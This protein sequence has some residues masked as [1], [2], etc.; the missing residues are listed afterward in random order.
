M[1]RNLSPALIFFV[2]CIALGLTPARAAE[3]SASTDTTGPK[4]DAPVVLSIFQVTGDRDE[5][6][7]S[8]QTISGSR[9]LENL[10]DIPNS[11]SIMNRELIEDLNATTVSE[12]SAFAVTGEVSDNTESTVANYVFRGIVSNTPLRNGIIWFSPLDTYSIERVE[13]LRGPNAFLYG[14]GTAGGSMNQLTKQ[15][16]AQNFNKANLVFGSNDLYRGELDVNRKLTDTLALRVNLA[17]QK[18]GS[19]VNHAKREFKGAYLA[20]AW[21]PTRSTNITVNL[22]AGKIHEVRPDTILT[23]VFSTTQRTGTAGTYTNTVGGVTLLSA[24]GQIINTVGT[25]RSTGTNIIVTDETVLPREYNFFGPNSFLDVD[26]TAEN[27]NIAQKFGENLTIQASLANQQIIRNSRTN[28]GSSS[29]GIYLD[30]NPTLPGGAANPNFN[31]YYTEYYVRRRWLEEPIHDARITV[32]YDLKLPFT[33]QRI[34]AAGTYHD[35]APEGY[36]SSEFV[37]AANPAFTGTVLNANTLA[38]YQAN[39]TTLSR[40]FFYRRF[41]LKDGDGSQLTSNA[42]VPGVS[43]MQ[44]DPVAEGAAGRLTHR[45]YKTPAYG[46]G[47]SGSYFKGRLRTLVGWRHDAFV[48]SPERIFYNPVTGVEYP[49]PAAKVD[50]DIGKRS[51]NLGGVVHFANFVSGYINYAQSVGLSAGI[52]GAGLIPGTVRGVAAGDGYEYGLRWSLL[53]GRLE[54]NWTYY[55]T[56]VLNQSASPGITTVVRTELGALFTDI[57]PSGGDTQSTKAKGFEFETVANLTSNWRLMWNY[58]TNELETSDRYPALNLYRARAKAE[59]KPTPE[60]DAFLS[61]S[62]AGTPVPGF[63]KTRSNLVTNYRF[64]QGALKGA[65]IGGGFQ[66]RSKAYRGNFDLNRDGVAEMLWSPPYFVGNVMMGYRTKLMNRP[67]S[68][69]L[70]LNNILDK[71]YYRSY[72]LASGAWGEGRNFRCSIR[73]EF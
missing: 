10:R 56:N 69:N 44:R 53:G 17:Y 45:K 55:I 6:Y 58:S 52:G 7:R 41:Y 63:T 43:V 48:Q 15:A 8:T 18:A 22:E 27:I 66:Y 31:Q 11:I 9:T 54:S 40:N 25:R 51:Y 46:I 24:T 20:G 71:D 62:P 65:S 32:V 57:D 5:G 60:T 34:V 33:T 1:E 35:D 59:N 68:F 64:T 23:D 47:M 39:V 3:T 72:G 42:P 13:L 21:N 12:L 30:L 26:Y 16:T 38:A 61:T 4:K 36:F 28:A 67:V 50:T 19:F 70:N 37:A 49:L 29:A 14:E 73:T 2:V